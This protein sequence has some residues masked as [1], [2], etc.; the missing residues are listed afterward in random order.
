MTAEFEN[1][2]RIIIVRQDHTAYLNEFSHIRSFIRP[3][4]SSPTCCRATLNCRLGSGHHANAFQF[5]HGQAILIVN[6]WNF[7]LV[8]L[9]MTGSDEGCTFLL[10]SE[11]S[12]VVTVNAPNLI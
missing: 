3:L 11:F 10:E 6:Q 8:R 1:Q 5:V 9:Y 4:S 2:F 12:A 7:Q